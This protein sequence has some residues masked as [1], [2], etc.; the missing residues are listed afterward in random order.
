MSDVRHLNL[1]LSQSFPCSY[2]ADQNEQLLI[3]RDPIDALQFEQLLALGFRRSGAQVYRPHCQQCEACVPV[4]VPVARFVPS[5]SQKRLLAK[6]EALT[7]RATT[8]PTAAQQALY[9]EYICQR[10]SDGPMYP[11]SLDQFERFLVCDWLDQLFLEGWLDEE[12]VVVAVTDLLPHAL[13][14]TYTFFQPEQAALS[15]G[16]RAVLAQIGLAQQLGRDYLYLGYQIDDCAKMAY[17]T[18]FRP[19]EHLQGHR[20]L[21]WP[22]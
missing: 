20:W 7:W 10:H 1:G 21:D 5:R 8:R 12:L 16:T 3:N 18:R 19:I 17:K 11:P 14:A 13:S 2:L 4:R 15:L 22:G 9:L 6:T